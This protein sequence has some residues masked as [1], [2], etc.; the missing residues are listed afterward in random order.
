MANDYIDTASTTLV[1]VTADSSSTFCTSCSSFYVGYHQCCSPI[2]T[3]GASPT[4]DVDGLIKQLVK[5]SEEIG[6][7]RALLS[8][9]KATQGVHNGNRKRRRHT[10]TRL[11]K[12]DYC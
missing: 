8:K 4:I 2:I 11:Q 7:L 6:R 9:S 1:G 12:K 3:Y 5:M 10:R